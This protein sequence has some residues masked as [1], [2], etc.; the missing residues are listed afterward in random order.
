MVSSEPGD[1]I[2]DDEE[3]SRLK[4]L[5]INSLRICPLYQM[6]TD[7]ALRLLRPKEFYLSLIRKAKDEG[8]AVFLEPNLFI[9][10]A[11]LQLSDPESIE[12]I[13]AMS[14][15]WAAIA[16]EEGVE[17]YSPLNEPD[18]LFGRNQDLIAEWI[19]KTRELRTLFSGYLV[20]KFADLGPDE[21]EGI[22]HY[23]YVAFDIIW[24]DNRLDELREHLR[25]AI[26][27]GGELRKQYGLRGFF[28]GELGAEKARVDERT[29]AE[30]F[31][32]ILE[33]TWGKVDGY[34]FLGWSELEFSFKG[35]EGEKVIAEW[36]SRPP[37]EVEPATVG[38][39]PVYPMAAE[40]E[41]PEEMKAQF[42]IDESLE[43]RGYHVG[44]PAAEI[45][46]WYK[47]Y[48]SQWLLVREDSFSP[49][50]RPE[51]AFYLAFFR[52]GDDGA[53]IFITVGARGYSFLG[54]ATGP[55]SMVQ[56]CGGPPAEEPMGREG[57]APWLGKPKM[58]DGIDWSQAQVW[59]DPRG[60]FWLGEGSPPQVIEFPPSDIVRVLLL[61][62]SQYL[63]LRFEM[64]GEFP[65]LPL[66]HDGD[67]VRIVMVDFL[68]DLDRNRQTG[69]AMRYAGADLALE[70][71]FGSPPEARG[72]LYY[73]AQYAFYDAQAPEE[74]GEWRQ[75]TLVA[76]GVGADFVTLRFP[77]AELKLESGMK[78]DAFI[79]AEAESDLYH[80]FARDVLGEEKQWHPVEIR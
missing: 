2:L 51:G 42:G 15:E 43:S 72:E 31:R 26:A 6:S 80:H 78:I 11:G 49:P 64:D 3:I 28:F 35:R 27:K 59:E 19:R 25:R 45:L 54:I 30:I 23:D 46:D 62:D 22:D 14:S 1:Y 4:S 56:R 32:T 8:F 34:D 53:F 76:G 9:G 17:L 68:I 65:V 16:E 75:G 5:N 36:F 73:Y 79:F 55:W 47:A 70:A 60:D 33:E 41:L 61:N 71:W 20:L 58:E 21:I 63:Y 77:L 29:Q 57:P 18:L 24:G 74:I 50:D 7:G 38:E 10:G 48:A 52:K 40:A 66:A 67:T 13:L 37:P 39:F 69:K 12:K 44:A